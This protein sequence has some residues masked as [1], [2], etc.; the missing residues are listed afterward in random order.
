MSNLFARRRPLR[1]TTVKTALYSFS[2]LAC[3]TFLAFPE[4]AFA[5][6][7]LT[8]PKIVTSSPTGVNLADGSFSLASED[9]SIGGLT[10]TRSYSTAPETSNHYFGSGWT[11]NFDIW[12]R[13]NFFNGEYTIDVVIG[14]SSHRFTGTLSVNYPVNDDIGTSIA[15]VSGVVKFTDRDGT[16][17]EFPNGSYTKVSRII[18]P[19]GEILK[20][21]YASDRPK[22][23]SS[24]KGIAILF[25]Y[26]GG[27]VSAACTYNLAAT[28]VTAASTCAA[29]PYKVAYTYASSRLSAFQDL[30]GASTGYA[31]GTY[32]ALTCVTLPG[33]SACKITNTYTP[34]PHGLPLNYNTLDVTQ[35]VLADGSVWKYDCSCGSGLTADPDDPFPLD[36]NTV[37]EPNGEK[38]S[39]V[40]SN[41]NQPY[42]KTDEG[43]RQTRYQFVGALPWK[44]TYPEG[45]S[46]NWL[47][48]ARQADGGNRYT[49]KAGS[50]LADI[51]SGAK[52]YPSTCTNSITCNLPVTVAD[53]NGNIT[54]YTYDSSHGGILTETQP[55][56][57]GVSPV[58]RHAYSQRYAWIKNAGGSFVHGPSPIWVRTETR[59]CRTTA[60]ASGSCAGG[61]SDEVVTSYDYGPDSGAA[62]NALFL[63]GKL[64][65]A[66]GQSLRTCYGYDEQGNKIWETSPRAG[67]AACY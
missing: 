49:A 4:N 16:V 23:I 18:S 45:N 34:N 22:L 29:A 67:L 14:R 60:T 59:T 21:D 38:Y 63:R 32:G 25:D 2:A 64:V 52:T 26:S 7:Q 65:T 28:Y 6:T 51:T 5:Q 12:F 10:L 53:A 33:S 1:S 37:T 44:A 48:S 9:L 61:P 39:W 46:V 43:G 66:D 58:V 35:Q 54:S 47:Y 19:N 27:N 17:Y 57:G 13:Q 3:S 41:G 55:A 8:P 24:N 56:I 30:T 40:F 31:Y 11:H 50:G 42:I 62:G 15:L 36:Y 20:F